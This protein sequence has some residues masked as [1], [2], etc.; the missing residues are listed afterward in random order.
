MFFKLFIISGPSILSEKK[1]FIDDNS[2]QENCQ[3]FNAFACF[4]FLCFWFL[5]YVFSDFLWAVKN[6]IWTLLYCCGGQYF[7]ICQVL[8]CNYLTD[9]NRYIFAAALSILCYNVL[10]LIFYQSSWLLSK[11]LPT[12]SLKIVKHYLREE[13]YW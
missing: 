10:P 7:F 13:R 11:L 9:G 6:C 3:D 8:I 1:K 2:L 4:F 12:D 5:F